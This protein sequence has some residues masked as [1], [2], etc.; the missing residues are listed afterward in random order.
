[1]GCETAGDKIKEQ[2]VRG[3]NDW[4]AD[5]RGNALALE[6]LEKLK[7]EPKMEL[8][9]YLRAFKNLAYLREPSLVVNDEP[10]RHEAEDEIW[11]VKK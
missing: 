10:E 2:W 5:R 1:M 9:E 8:S 6:F 3:V 7:K 11:K 4:R